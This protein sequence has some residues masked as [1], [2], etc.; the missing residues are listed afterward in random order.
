MKAIMVA[1]FALA[2]FAAEANTC[3]PGTVV[4][5]EL[6][7]LTAISAV[8]HVSTDLVGPHYLSDA[9]KPDGLNPF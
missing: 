7:L 2:P 8:S 4:V 5:D 3:L 9:W 1:L 6:S